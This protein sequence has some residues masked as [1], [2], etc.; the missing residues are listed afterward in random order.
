MKYINLQDALDLVPD[1]IALEL[2][3]YCYQLEYMTDIGRKLS[4]QK[5]VLHGLKQKDILRL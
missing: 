5:A 3:Q 2:E 1:E 4:Y